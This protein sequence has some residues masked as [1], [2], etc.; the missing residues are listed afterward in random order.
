M[1]TIL[2]TGAK[3]F[4][5]RSII[6]ELN[7][8]HNI[9]GLDS[10]DGHD[11]TNIK[12]FAHIKG[13]VDIAIHLAGLTFVPES[14][15]KPFEY[16]KVN[17]NT[18][19][20]VAEFCRQRNIKTIVYLNTY[21]YGNPI[22]LPID[23]THPI[24]LNTPYHKSKMLA[25]DLILNYPYIKTKVISLRM[26]NIYGPLQAPHFLLSKIIN[27]ALKIGKI[28]VFD[29]EPRRDYIYIK[30]FINLIKIII[31]LDKPTPGVYNVGFGQS[32]SVADIIHTLESFLNK[33]LIVINLNKR[34]SGEIMDC[35]ADI[36]KTSKEFK[37]IPKYSV[38]NGLQ[39]YIKEISY[40]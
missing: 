38:Y 7:N 37:W 14:F 30:D 31:D 19:L 4:I 22:K 25:E 36:R 35:Y 23:E 34:R 1:K 32:H 11:L 24:S 26:F 27:Q 33:K 21:V 15:E 29:L 17:I 40:V 28:E 3:G 16:Y 10:V 39:D 13:E 12:S 18:S 9:I 20:N 8:Q 6:Q 2:I 5:G